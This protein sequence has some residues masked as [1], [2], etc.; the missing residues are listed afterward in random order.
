MAS[1][2][3]KNDAQVLA[4]VSEGNAGLGLHPAAVPNGPWF[5]SALPEIMLKMACSSAGA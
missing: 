4:C 1:V 2:S 5:G 3:N